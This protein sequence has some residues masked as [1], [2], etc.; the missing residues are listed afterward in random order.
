MHLGWLPVLNTAVIGV[1]YVTVSALICFRG[2]GSTLNGDSG[3]L[4][5][6]GFIAWALFSFFLFDAR[7]A[8]QEYGRE[9]QSAHRQ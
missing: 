4:I 9:Q 1:F 6:V 7:R 2:I 5:T 8:A 3:A